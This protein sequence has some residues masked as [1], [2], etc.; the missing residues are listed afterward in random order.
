[1]TLVMTMA[2]TMKKKV[3]IKLFSRFNIIGDSLLV[4]NS[5]WWVLINNKILCTSFSVILNSLFIILLVCA[6]CFCLC[7]IPLF[8]L[9]YTTRRTSVGSHDDAGGYYNGYS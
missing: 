3:N 5:R 8:F 9:P 4:T 7:F 6:V 1:M 2:D